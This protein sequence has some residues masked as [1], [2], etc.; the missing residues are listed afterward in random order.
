M[1]IALVAFTILPVLETGKWILRR[2]ERAGRPSASPPRARSV[3]AGRID[4]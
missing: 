3:G 2:T 4:I 1:M